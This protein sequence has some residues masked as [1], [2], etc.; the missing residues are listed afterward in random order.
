MSSMAG[1]VIKRAKYKTY[2][3]SIKDPGTP[4]LLTMMKHS[5]VF[6]PSD[7][8]SPANLDV[9]FQLLKGQ[10]NTKDGSNKPPWLNITNTK[11]ENYILE[12]ETYPDLHACRQIISNALEAAK[13]SSATTIFSASSSAYEQFSTAELELRIKLMQEDGE[14]QKLHKQFVGSGVLTESEFWATRK[15]L[16]YGDSRKKSKQ[17]VGFKSSMILDIKPVTDGR[18]NKVTFNLTD[19]IKYQIFA[20]KPAVHQ[21]FINLVPSKMTEKDFWNKY[22]R[23]EYLHSTKNVVAAAAEAAEDEELAIFLKEDEILAKETRQKIQ[24]VD[25]ILDMEADQGDDYTHIPD[26]GIFRDG[27][28]DITEQ[29]NEQYSRSLSQDLN[30]QGTVVLQGRNLDVDPEDPRSIAEVLMRS[31]QDP[32]DSAVHERLDRI[33]WMTEIDDLQESHDHPVAPLCIKVNIVF[34]M[35]LETNFDTQQA[36]ALRI[37]DDSCGTEQT[38]RKLTT[39]EAYGSLKESISNIK[40]IGLSNSTVKPEIALTVGRLKDAMSQIYRGI[41]SAGAPSCVI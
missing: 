12:F 27:N 24:Q 35:I 7:P 38:K 15:R 17:R 36:N 14:L 18:M 22:F 33:T 32:S 34:T 11:D 21:A 6:R 25:P 28:K 5:F 19:E 4:G 23:A 9:P 41:F 2:M 3:S 37:L 10:K 20:L 30:R 1:Q 26:H 13:G 8:T 31:R 29:Q 39:E 16:L 40:S